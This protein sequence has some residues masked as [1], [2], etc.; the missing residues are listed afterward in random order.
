[1]NLK[2]TPGVITVFNLQTHQPI[3]L[4]FRMMD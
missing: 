3:D 4:D 2:P 1:M